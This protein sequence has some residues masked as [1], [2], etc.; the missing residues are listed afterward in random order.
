MV[1]NFLSCISFSSSIVFYA[2]IS[3]LS[4][5]VSIYSDFLTCISFF[6]FCILI[7]KISVS[8]VSDHLVMSNKVYKRDSAYFSKVG[9]LNHGLDQ[10]FPT[11]HRE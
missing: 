10:L 1:A 9:T 4:F 2:S 6:K 5:F 3:E 8:N 7:G 11:F